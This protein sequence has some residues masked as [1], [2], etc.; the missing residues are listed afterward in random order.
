M[1]DLLKI[2]DSTDITLKTKSLENL[3]K[4]LSFS[5][6]YPTR[7]LYFITINLAI[8]HFSF[9]DVTI[10]DGR[11]YVIIKCGYKNL[12]NTQKNII[13]ICIPEDNISDHITNLI[14]TIYEAHKENKLVIITGERA[15]FAIILYYY[16]QTQV[17]LKKH[18]LEY[19]ISTLCIKYPAFILS[20]FEILYMLK[21]EKARY[22]ESK[23]RFKKYKTIAPITK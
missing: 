5:V 16:L 23:V 1:S 8:Y 20:K 13:N 3:E 14:T 17:Y 7:N 2:I 12:K 22:G 15:C 6:S 19:L 4:I 9:N 11:S 18:F 10:P 21:I